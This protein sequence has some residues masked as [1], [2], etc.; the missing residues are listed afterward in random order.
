VY[1]VLVVGVTDIEPERFCAPLHAPL[2]VHAVAFFEA[3]ERFEAVPAGIEAG[4]AEK[5]S[6]GT[7][8]GFGRTVTV[9]DFVTAPQEPVQFAV[10]VVVT[11]GLTDLVPPELARDDGQ[12]GSFGDEVVVHPYIVF[13]IVGVHV[14]T[15]EPK[16]EVIVEGFAVKF[17][18][19]S[20]GLTGTLIV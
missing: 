20:F 11:V 8:L 13:A 14:I 4:V 5:V 15:E 6:T 17:N 12:N 10:Y 7:G 1:V 9:T 18:L 3:H 16:P 2:A 19:S